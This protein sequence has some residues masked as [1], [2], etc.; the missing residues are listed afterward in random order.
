[1]RSSSELR[2]FYFLRHMEREKTAVFIGHSNCD[3]SIEKISQIIEGEI[4]KGIKYFL[5][6]GQGAF[7]RLCARAVYNLKSKN[8]DIKNIL[9]IPY[10]NFKIFDKSLFDE[11]ISPNIDYNSKKAYK[12]AIPR[13]NKYMIENACTAICYINHISG[14]AYKTYKLAEKKNLFVINIIIEE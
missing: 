6:G 14:G 4:K 13:R 1:M 7:D 2:F 10:S 12:S 3:L 9:V 11:I 8:P 5:N